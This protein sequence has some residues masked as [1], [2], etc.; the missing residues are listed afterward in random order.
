MSRV[1]AAGTFDRKFGRNVRLISLLERAGHEVVLCQSDI[2]G[3][4]KYDIVR[5]GKGSMLVRGLVAYPRV[6]WRLVRT[7]RA[8]AVLT[9]YPGWFDTIVLAP[10]ARLRST[11]L[12]FDIYISLSDTIVSDRQ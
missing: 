1:V 7:P 3:S 11:P 8:D 6:V 2:F 9:M 10:V 12:I 5:G 4:T